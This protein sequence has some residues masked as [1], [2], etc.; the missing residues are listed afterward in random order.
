MEQATHIRLDSVQAL[1]LLV[2]VHEHVAVNLVDEHFVPDVGLHLVG[3]SDHFEKLLASAFIVS[4]V[5][6]DHV[7]KGSAVGDLL[8]RVRLKHEVAWEVD[9]AELDV[10]V[11]ADS[12]HLDVAR[13][14]QEE[15][16]VRAH[17]LEDYLGDGCFARSERSRK[18]TREVRRFAAEGVC[19]G[20][21][22]TYLG[23]PIRQM[24]IFLFFN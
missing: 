7:D 21:M 23:I 20:W 18:K 4:V 19:D 1:N 15:G 16:L 8:G 24:F 13:W 9:Y 22:S 12:L 17:L 5:S 2:V 10:V 6:I 11:I 3:L 14:Q